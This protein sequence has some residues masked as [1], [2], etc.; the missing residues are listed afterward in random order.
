MQATLTRS[1]AVKLMLGLLA[2]EILSAFELSMLYAALRSMIADFGNPEAVGWVM[3]SFLLASAVSAAICGRLG[4]IFGRKRVLLAVIVF[5]IIGSLIAG[6]ASTIGW[7][8]VGRVIQGTAGAIFP[9]CIGLVRENVKPQSAPLFIGTLA[10]TLTV[11]M[12]LGMLLGGIIVDQLNWHWIFFAGAIAGVV[13]FIA[14]YC[15][16]PVSATKPYD[17]RTN[18]LGGI[19]FAPAVVFLLLG[20]TKAPS[21]GWGSNSTLACLLAGIVLLLAWIRSELRAEAPLLDV[22]LL[23]NRQVLLVNLGSAVLGLTSFQ[24]MQMWS[25]VLQQPTIS[26][27]G[28]GVSAT[29]A[30]MVL[31]P[32]TLIALASGPAAG[33]LISRFNGRL[34][35]ATGASIMAFAWILLA[36]KHDSVLLMVFQ[37]TLLGFGMSMFYS[38]VPIL[39]AQAVPM[40]RTSEA[41]GM[42]IVI[43]ST[44]MGIGAQIVA[45]LLDSSTVTIAGA[46]YPDQTAVYRVIAYV[47]AGCVAMIIIAMLV[48]KQSPDK[49]TQSAAHSAIPLPN[50]TVS[51]AGK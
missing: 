47:I 7:V 37:F 43:R 12:G 51:A 39:L 25:I 20:I 30:G 2:A 22:R 18:L 1:N 13:A 33:W 3:T 50:S 6:F 23:L 45:F 41:S 40:E 31:F 17:R 24:S 38:S 46:S 42:M 29:V 14:I 16:M 27:V 26:G 9:L 8:V 5:S 21:W 19:L 35:M 44:A 11:T 49:S 36:F 10:A 34:A 32:K 48:S 4:D 15:W 28:L